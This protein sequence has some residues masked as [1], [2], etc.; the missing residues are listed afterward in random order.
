MKTQNWWTGS[1][2]WWFWGGLTAL[3]VFCLTYFDVRLS[4]KSGIILGAIEIVVFM[5][6]SLTLLAEHPNST[7]PFHPGNS[8]GGYRGI[9][10]A[11]VFVITAFIG[12]EAATALGEESRNPRK[13]VPRG[14]VWAALRSGSS[15]CSTPTPG[16]SAPT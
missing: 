6:L 1:P 13:T 7:A 8:A 12:F 2:G 4:A 11:S 10:Q 16:T 3:V 14:V 15:T 9:F 5:A